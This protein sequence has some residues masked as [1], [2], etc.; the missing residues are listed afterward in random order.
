M[1]KRSGAVYFCN[2]SFLAIGVFLGAFLLME[3][4]A[5]VVHKYLLHGPLWFLHRSHHVP[6]KHSFEWNDLVVLVYAVPSAVLTYTGLKS[7]QEVL[8]AAGLGIAAYGL[9][10]FFL[11]DVV[12]HRRVKWLRKP[13][14]KYFRAVVRGHKV[15]HKSLGKKGSQVFGFLWVPRRFYRELR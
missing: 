2:M 1:D 13:N 12:T 4:I 3:A 9:A 5:W 15:H 7:H 14:G 6:H 11:H 10:Y 8:T